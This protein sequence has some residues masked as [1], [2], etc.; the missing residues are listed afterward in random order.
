M[1]RV[2]VSSLLGVFGVKYKRYQIYECPHPSPAIPGQ[3]KVHPVTAEILADAQQELRQV[4]FD[5]SEAR[6][7][8]IAVDGELA[9]VCWYWFGARYREKRGFITLPAKGAKLVQIVTAQEYRGRGLATTLIAG[10]AQAMRSQGFE[11]LLARVWHSN[12]SSRR[13]FRK[14]GWNERE[15]INVVT[16][17]PFGPIR[18]TQRSASQSR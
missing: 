1:A 9:S 5:G 3:E 2:P 11:T 12:H 6:G 7:F 10:S 16:I 15:M 17:G 13:A 4:G 14:A 8:G 18:Y